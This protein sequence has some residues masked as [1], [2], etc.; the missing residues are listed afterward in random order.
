MNIA[1]TSSLPARWKK[2]AVYAGAAFVLYSITGFLILPAIVKWQIRHQLPAITR[3]NVEVA[4]VR[5]NPY[6][7]SLTVRG[8]KLTEP[9][10][11]PFASL[12]EFH[13]NF[14]S[15]SLLRWRWQFREIKLTAPALWLVVH[16]D[17]TPN[18]ANLMPASS[19]APSSPSTLPR[20]VVET[21][22][23]AAGS[24]DVT[25]HA[26]ARPFHHRIDPVDVI[27]RDFSTLPERDRPYSFTARTAAGETF[28]WSGDISINPVRSEG[29]IECHNIALSQYMAVLPETFRARIDSGLLHVAGAYRLS[30]GDEIELAVTNTTVRVSQFKL[31][32]TQSDT[33]LLDLPDLV[34]ADTEADL[35]RRSARVGSIIVNGGVTHLERESDGNTN[36]Q[37]LGDLSPVLNLVAGWQIQLDDIKVNEFA[38]RAADKKL[39]RKPSVVLDQIGVHL[40]HISNRSNT[41]VPV[42]LSLRWNNAGTVRVNGRASLIPVTADLDVAVDELDLRPLQP[43]AAEFANIAV[44]NGAVRLKGHVTFNPRAD[45]GAIIKFEGETGIARLAA[46]DT[47]LNQQLVTLEDLAVTGIRATVP[48]MRVHVARVAVTGLDARVARDPEERINLLH[49]VK[50]RTAPAAAPVPATDSTGTAP[51]PEVTVDEVWLENVGLR[52]ADES[53]KPSFLTVLRDVTGSIKGLSSKELARADVNLR[54]R[55][56]NSPPFTLTG[57]INPL[58]TNV[59]TDL[60]LTIQDVPLPA[61]STYAGRYGGFP[62]ENGTVTLDLQYRVNQAELVAENKITVNRLQLGAH[63][64]SPD[65]TKLPVKLAIALLTDPRGQIKLDVPVR[66]NLNDPEFRVGKVILQVVSNLIVKAATSPFNLLASIVGADA[67]DLS[68]I[69]FQPGVSTPLASDEPKFALLEKILAER[70]ALKLVVTGTTDPAT[71]RDA[72]ARYKLLLTLKEARLKEQPIQRMRG[73]TPDQ[74]ELDRA[75]FERLLKEHY[76]TVTGAAQTSSRPANSRS[77]PVP[78]RPAKTNAAAAEP[79]IEEMERALIAAISVTDDELA[80]LRRQRAQVVLDRLSQNADLAGRVTSDAAAESD[81][82]LPA[83]PR[84]ALRLDL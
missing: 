27:L 19:T 80:A 25:H 41:V 60:K 72:I 31:V 73:A 43:Y 21:L 81:P 23:I 42:A 77:V 13:A 38:V 6:T 22:A 11:K 47:V 64:G 4:Q 2:R 67:P 34:V 63:T 45:D 14:E 53:M 52:V 49:L 40:Q 20:L 5:V 79:T 76:A 56:N 70:P 7:L 44:T 12:D 59:F 8:L 61:M 29:T 65:A 18:I 66:G 68:H 10:G 32:D 26:L 82:A 84:A 57:T 51:V 33:P 16:P 17:G 39:A 46:H 74:V 83:K 9:D 54:G 37:D 28:T 36:L 62:I 71:D 50:Q 48:D 24:V 35:R 15:V 75:N 1:A 78:K 30:M 58:T 69:G 55:I 3:R